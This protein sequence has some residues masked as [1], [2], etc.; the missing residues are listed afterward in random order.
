[1]SSFAEQVILK[2]SP[3][4][5]TLEKIRSLALAK[6]KMTQ[7]ALEDSLTDNNVICMLRSKLVALP[8]L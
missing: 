1:M 5:L 7:T 2:V 3:K 6:K 4:M 8:P